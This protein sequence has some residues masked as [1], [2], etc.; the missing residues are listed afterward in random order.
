ML[1]KEREDAEGKEQGSANFELQSHSRSLQNPPAQDLEK[2]MAEMEATHK[3]K[4]QQL[5]TDYQTAVRYVK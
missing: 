2:R 4:L 3:K 5:E 1:L